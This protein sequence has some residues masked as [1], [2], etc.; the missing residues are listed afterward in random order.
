MNRQIRN[1]HQIPAH[2]AEHLLYPLR[3]LH[4]QP[5]GH[6]KR[7]VKPRR[8][9]HSAVFFH[10]Q[11]HIMSLCLHLRMCLNLKHRRIT[12]AG[13]DLK[14]HR[15]TLRYPESQDCRAIADHKI[16]HSRFQLPVRSLQQLC[17]SLMNQLFSHIFYGM[18]C[19]R[20]LLYKR[21]ELLYGRLT[22]LSVVSFILCLYT[23]VACTF[24]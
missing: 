20:T 7:T 15:R 11:A 3:R 9:E 10:I 1:H 21:E 2:I 16:A 8:T 13:H 18:E 5:A 12:V 22:H 23:P 14:A 6:R 19:C 17:I 4:D 24:V